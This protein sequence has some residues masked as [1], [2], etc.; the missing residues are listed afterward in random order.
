MREL[1]ARRQRRMRE[2]S[3]VAAEA[4]RRIGSPSGIAAG[5]GSGDA[6]QGDATQRRNAT[7]RNATQHQRTSEG[8][9]RRGRRAAAERA[10]TTADARTHARTHAT[11]AT[12]EDDPQ[13][14]IQRERERKSG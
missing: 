3:H 13:V 1:G 9:R 4:R 8:K 7:Q 5:R 14:D 2:M 6:T 11:D 10:A 12:D